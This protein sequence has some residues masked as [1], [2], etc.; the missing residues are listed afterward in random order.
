MLKDDSRRCNSRS[1]SCSEE[2]IENIEERESRTVFEGQNI[3]KEWTIEDYV[4]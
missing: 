3:L 2:D 1:Y 4:R